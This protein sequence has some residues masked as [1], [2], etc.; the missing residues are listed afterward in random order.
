[1]GCAPAHC[2][3]TGCDG[4]LGTSWFAGNDCIVA[5][6]RQGDAEQSSAEPLAPGLICWQTEDRDH[7]STVISKT[8]HLMTVVIGERGPGHSQGTQERWAWLP[9]CFLV[10]QM[11]ATDVAKRMSTVL[12]CPLLLGLWSRFSKQQAW[13]ETPLWCN[14]KGIL[15]IALACYG[16]MSAI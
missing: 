10:T 13:T 2:C 12:T 3:A 15:C 8:V 7:V 9:R 6:V 16:I 5:R 1:M 4:E 11:L 14:L